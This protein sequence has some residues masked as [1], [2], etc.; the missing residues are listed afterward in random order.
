MHQNL[1]ATCITAYSV[2]QY[3]SQEDLGV[4]NSSVGC[5]SGIPWWK[6]FRQRMRNCLPAPGNGHSSNS[7]EIL[8]EVKQVRKT[9]QTCLLK[10]FFPVKLLSS[11]NRF[12]KP[13]PQTG[14]TCQLEQVLTSQTS[15]QNRSSQTGFKQVKQVWQTNFNQSNK[16]HKKGS[17]KWSNQFC[18]TGF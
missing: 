8:V 1:A 12:V 5:S 4:S 15:S 13:V 11:Q 17:S 3:W 16:F 6:D 14:Q 2:L 7:N 10:Q 9:G 18:K